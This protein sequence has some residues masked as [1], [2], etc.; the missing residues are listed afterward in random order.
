MEEVRKHFGIAQAVRIV[1][2]LALA[3]WAA[4]FAVPALM[5]GDAA[6]FKGHLLYMA[7]AVWL[8]L[9]RPGGWLNSVRMAD[10]T[11]KEK[12]IAAVMAAVVIYCLL[13]PMDLSPVWSGVKETYRNEYEV[14]SEALLN[15]HVYMDKEPSRELLAMENPYDFVARVKNNVPFPWDHAYYKGHFYM[16]Y[17]VV[18]EFLAFIPYRLITGHVLPGYHA[19]QAFVLV[20]V[21]GLFL[22]FYK[23]AR[24]L[25]PDM[26]FGMYL[27][28]SAGVSVLSFWYAS[29][30]PMLYCTAITSGICLEIWSLL[31][32]FQAGWCETSRV[33]QYA[34]II[35]GTFLGALTF[36]CRPTIGLANLICFPVVFELWRRREKTGV[37][38]SQFL[39]GIIPYILVIGALMYYN[40]V[41][42]ES[43][44]EFGQA[45]QLTSADQHEYGSMLSRFSW[46]TTLNGIRQQFFL[47]YDLSPDF[48]HVEFYGAYVNFPVLLLSWAYLRHDVRMSFRRDHLGWFAAVL[49]ALP[50]IITVMQ[51]QWAP[52]VAERYRMDIYFLMGIMTF[53]VCGYLVQNLPAGSRGNLA[54][55]TGI[56]CEL[57]AFSALLLFLVPF[58]NNIAILDPEYLAGWKAILTMGK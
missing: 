31:L 11:V 6:V 44:F 55:V 41:R 43:P 49:A 29:A 5:R 9:M 22:L 30:A 19:T 37:F 25:F 3:V 54:F 38:I 2:L 36:G 45:Y 1:F 24:R 14:M 50:L 46:F 47:L 56:L 7:A 52:V 4:V 51:I 48:P 23:F 18:P 15:G 20:S 58:D 32:L 33:K 34:E 28:L 53:L 8:F 27:S 35:L 39:C 21:I 57:A 40:Y 10:L 42:F 13:A 17:G 12:I 26:P 16:Y